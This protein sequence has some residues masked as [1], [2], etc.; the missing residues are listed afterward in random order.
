MR[1]ETL[2]KFRAAFLFFRM[3]HLFFLEYAEKDI[4][5]L[6]LKLIDELYLTS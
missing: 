3:E 2:W 1:R 4:I 6:P 5:I